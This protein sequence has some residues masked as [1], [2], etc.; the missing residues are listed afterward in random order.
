M[1]ESRGL[2]KAIVGVESA[3]YNMK[4]IDDVR[5]DSA[6][7]LMLAVLSKDEIEDDGIDVENFSENFLR[8]DG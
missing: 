2:I 6:P 1:C 4:I 3:T 7:L 5:G 8:S